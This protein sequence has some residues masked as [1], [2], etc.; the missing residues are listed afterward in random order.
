[1]LLNYMRSLARYLLF[2]LGLTTAAGAGGAVELDRIIAVVDED[3]VM[4][5]ELDGQM[6]RVRDQLRQLGLVQL[7]LSPPPR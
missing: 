7:L 2:L 3:V 4:Q 1:M 5:S 6:R